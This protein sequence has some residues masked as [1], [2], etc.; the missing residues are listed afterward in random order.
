[1]GPAVIGTAAVQINVLVSTYFASSIEGGP[2]WLS[3]AFRLMQFPIGVFGV[4]IGT[5]TIPAVSRFAS[6]RDIPSFRSTLASSLG[7]VFLLTI[8]SACGLVVLGRPI[9][10]MIYERGAFTST[11]TTM[12]TAA[13]AAYSVGLVG[14]AAVKVLSPSFYALDD[15]RTPMLISIA[16]I[17]INAAACYAFKDLFSGF[18]RTPDTPDGMAHVG[19]NILC[20]A[21]NLLCPALP[22]EEK[23]RWY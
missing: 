20:G 23:D 7:L 9:I 14:Y 2:S 11:D 1:M 10:A 8:P 16:D 5:A 21:G 12:V 13:L 6:L 15:P 4:A 3:Y 19:L 18:Y 17:G 22:Y